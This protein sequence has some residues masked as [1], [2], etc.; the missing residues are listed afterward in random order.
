[1]AVAEADHSY[2][3]RLAELSDTHGATAI[4][5]EIQDAPRPP[6]ERVEA[7]AKASDL[8]DGLPEEHG[9]AFAVFEVA[10][11]LEAAEAAWLDN[12]PDDLEARDDELPA[13]PGVYGD[14]DQADFDRQAVVVWS[15]GGVG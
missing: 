15:S 12:V 1:M 13:D 11:D 14:L 6:S 10:D 3:E 5:F 2:D 4:C 9:T 7:L 8:R